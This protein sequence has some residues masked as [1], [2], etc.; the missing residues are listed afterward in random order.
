MFMNVLSKY[1]IHYI[2][3][4]KINKIVQ[5]LTLSYSVVLA[6]W[7][8]ITPIISIYIIENIP[9][10]GLEAVGIGTTIYLLTRSVMQLPIAYMLDKK[11]GEK[12]DFFALFIGLVLVGTAAFA[13]TAVVNVWQLYVIQILYGLGDALIYP[14][15]GSLFTRHL[16]KDKIATE[17]SLFQAS[18]D[19]S[20]ALSASLGAL[21]ILKFGYH[22]VFLI[23]GAATW[24]GAFLLIPMYR[25]LYLK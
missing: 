5:L 2:A 9:N 7:G 21:L 11:R 4:L 24:L 22:P 1:S 23:V 8:L 12:D 14:S 25:S 18:A 20:S 6:G 16:D 17:T 19:L 3:Q 13:F 15:W 10:A